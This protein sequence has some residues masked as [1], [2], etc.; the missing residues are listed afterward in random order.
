[1][2][3]ASPSWAVLVAMWTLHVDHVVGEVVRALRTAGI[4]PILLKGAST[5]RWLYADGTPRTYGDVD[6]LIQACEWQ[7][8]VGVL[9]GLGFHDRQGDMQHPGMA[10]PASWAW[11]REEGADVDLHSTLEDVGV[12]AEALWR[13][14]SRD[15]V[16]MDVGGED[17]RILSEPARALHIALHALHHGVQADRTLEDLRR[18]IATVPEA[19][20]HRAAELAQRLDA[21][22]GL[23]SG[24]RLLPEGEDLAGRIGVGSAR[25][26]RTS[27]KSIDV[28]LAQGFGE[29]A[30]APGARAKLEF[31]G[32]E[33]VPTAEFMRWWSPL[34]RRG[35]PG[36]VLA[37]PWRLL[38]LAARAPA[39]LRAWRRAVR[40]APRRANRES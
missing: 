9:E 14:L 33:L 15:A 29:L 34:A 36:L 17:V 21:A 18:A 28:P 35:R 6:L 12:P 38:Y 8:A 26:V 39:G 32:R 10:S 27:L 3:A 13:E 23:A 25:S 31:I 4:D 19:T 37:Y 24:L 1:M 40:D 2:P 20:W 7:R 11:T 30:A 16:T 5:A 22:A